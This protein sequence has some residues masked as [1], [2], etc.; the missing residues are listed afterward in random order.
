[1]HQDAVRTLG[2]HKDDVNHTRCFPPKQTQPRHRKQRWDHAKIWNVG[3]AQFKTLYG[4][5]KA[6][7]PHHAVHPGGFLCLCQDVQAAVRKLAPGTLGTPPAILAA[8]ALFFCVQIDGKYSTNLE[9]IRHQPRPPGLSAR[10][11]G[12]QPFSFLRCR[13]SAASPPH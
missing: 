7:L 5:W 2:G 12:P 13:A 8:A 1:M 10:A 11:S 4:K 9:R 3:G 6:S